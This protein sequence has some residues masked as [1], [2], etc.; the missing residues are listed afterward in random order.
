METGDLYSELQER[1][2]RA[3]SDLGV[4]LFTTRQVR[5]LTVIELLGDLL[6]VRHA[7]QLADQAALPRG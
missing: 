3:K 6:L 4:S 5:D 7:A 1:Y 2:E